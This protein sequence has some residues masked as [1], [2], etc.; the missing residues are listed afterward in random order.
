[1]SKTKQTAYRLEIKLINRIDRFARQRM[2]EQRG[3][4]MT[5]ADAVRYL[6]TYALDNL[7]S[8]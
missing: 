1:M 7:D 6:L 8:S 3:I 4:V 5:R 2:R